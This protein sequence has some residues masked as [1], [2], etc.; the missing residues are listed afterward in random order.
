VFSGA[1]GRF[2]LIDRDLNLPGTGS[3]HGSQMLVELRQ[4]RQG[5]AVLAGSAKQV[6]LGHHQ[7]VAPAQLPALPH[8]SIVR[9][10][11]V[12]AEARP[13]ESL[14]CR[15]KRIDAGR[16]CPIVH[17]IAGIKGEHDKACREAKI[18]VL[19]GLEVIGIGTVA[20]PPALLKNSPRGVIEHLFGRASCAF[21]LT[22]GLLRKHGENPRAAAHRSHVPGRRQAESIPK[23]RTPPRAHRYRRH[24]WQERPETHEVRMAEHTLAQH[25][26]RASPGY[27]PGCQLQPERIG[28]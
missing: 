14:I 17:M 23:T 2:R 13:G 16:F 19:G 24:P 26:L 10:L 20:G 12:G 6:H 9:A 22:D 4:V 15:A 8:V 5:T 28:I 1:R 7:Q 18:D 3:D 21:H 11:R 25:C 27:L